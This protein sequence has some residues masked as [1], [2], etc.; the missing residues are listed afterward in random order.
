MMTIFAAIDLI[1]GA[2][3]FIW[4]L[5]LCSFAAIIVIIERTIA[6]QTGNVVPPDEL[7]Q[8]S[9]GVL[10][11]DNSKSSL[12]RILTRIKDEE[13]NEETIRAYAEMEATRLERGLQ[14][15]DLVVSGAPMLGLLGTVWGL[16][17]VFGAVSPET[18]I[19]EMGS[20]IHGIAL[21]LTT[22]LL[23][24]II[25]ILALVGVN[26]LNRRVEILS[27]KLAVAAEKA[28]SLRRNGS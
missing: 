26:L 24:L 21:A 8:L 17:H 13:N 28:L 18:G 14:V 10:P 20:F 15:L 3:W 22:T 1:Q 25:A 7:E 4:P 5:G 11:P 16:V 12:G 27:S 9:R 6:L 23:G 19:P 2:G